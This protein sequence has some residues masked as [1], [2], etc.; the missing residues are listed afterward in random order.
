MIA[1]AEQRLDRTLDHGV[2]QDEQRGGDE[3][4]RTTGIAPDPV[5]PRQVGGLRRRTKTAAP[6]RTWNST[7][8]KTT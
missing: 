3:E 8:A 5:G 4:Q 7:A 2:D 1:D 6:V